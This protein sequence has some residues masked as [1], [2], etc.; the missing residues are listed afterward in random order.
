MVSSGSDG[1]R[2]VTYQVVYDDGKE[3]RRQSIKADVVRQP[4][5]HVTA[6]GS[7]PAGRSATPAP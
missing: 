5:P 2:I 3:V 1:Q 6:V 7:G 4:V